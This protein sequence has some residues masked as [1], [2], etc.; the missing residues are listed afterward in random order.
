MEAGTM[1]VSSCKDCPY[2]VGV[3]GEEI[4]CSLDNDPRECTVWEGDE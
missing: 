3:R 1:I 4:I 2:N